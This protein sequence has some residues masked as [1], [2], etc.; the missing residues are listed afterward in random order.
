[1]GEIHAPQP[2]KLIVSLLGGQRD[3]L[4][5]AQA[6]LADRFGV[7][8]YAS[9]ALPFVQ[10]PYYEAEFGPS[11]LRRIV[12]FRRLVDPGELAA[13]KRLTNDWEQEWSSGGRRQ[14]NL[15][16]GYVSMAKLVLATTKNFAHRIYIGQGI[17]AEVTLRYA[18]GGFQP[19]PWTYPDY[20]SEEYRAIFGEIRARYAQQLRDA[21]GGR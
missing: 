1:M 20:A 21:S 8:D 17:F 16:P 3:L 12:A 18:K 11:L 2:V 13:I 5:T 4:E 6:R 19:W 14:I 15:D 7:C 9:A 10:T